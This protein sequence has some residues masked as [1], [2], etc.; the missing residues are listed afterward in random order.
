MLLAERLRK[1]NMMTS[2][3]HSNDGTKQHIIVV[4]NGMVGHHFVEQLIELGGMDEYRVTVLGEEANLAYDRVHL[5]DYFNGASA[6]DLA[7]TT[8]AYYAEHDVAFNTSSKVVVLDR[9]AKMV[10]LEGGEQLELRRLRD[11]EGVGVLLPPHVLPGKA[12]PEALL[13]EEVG[14]L[15]RG[16]KAALGT[17]SH[18]RSQGQRQSASAP[19]RRRPDRL[20]CRRTDG[21]G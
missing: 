19:C 20:L 2:F 5:S 8:S 12:W 15:G 10:T 3:T 11:R 21:R 14:D 13:V 1:G 17:I 18:G 9:G 16:A 4:G 6:A 7:M